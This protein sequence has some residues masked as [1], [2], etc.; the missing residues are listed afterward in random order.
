MAVMIEDLQVEE[1]APATASSN[2]N[3]PTP[4]ANAASALDERALRELLARDAWRAQR[5]R[6]D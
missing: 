5:L 2:A 6:A 1:A 3:A 4:S